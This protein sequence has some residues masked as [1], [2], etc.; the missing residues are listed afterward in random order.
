MLKKKNRKSYGVFED[1]FLSQCYVKKKKERVTHVHL[2]VTIGPFSS[3]IY[4]Y[5]PKT[6]MMSINDDPIG[7]FSLQRMIRYSREGKATLLHHPQ[8]WKY[9]IDQGIVIGNESEKYD[10]DSMKKGVSS[11]P[12]KLVKKK[13]SFLRGVMDKI[14][15]IKIN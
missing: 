5:E 6:E 13:K 9:L 14:P 15:T 1:N 4:R 8:T 11:P 10:L 12:P 7:H 3:G 2:L